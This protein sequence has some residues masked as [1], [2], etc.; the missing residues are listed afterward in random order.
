MIDADGTVPAGVCAL[1]AWSQ[2]WKPEETAEMEGM[3][4]A[5]ARA[6]ALNLKALNKYCHM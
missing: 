5:C 4:T 3:W 2:V 1:H 6:H